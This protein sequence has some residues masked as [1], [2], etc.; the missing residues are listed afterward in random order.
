MAACENGSNLH[1]I[2]VST[3]VAI[4]KDKNSPHAVR[5]AIDN[6]AM[7]NPQITLIHVKR[8]TQCRYH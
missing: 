5:W 2:S 1:I 7:S 3:A 6:L 4:D 8:K